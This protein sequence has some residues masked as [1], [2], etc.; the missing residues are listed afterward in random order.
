MAKRTKW[1]TISRTLANGKTIKVRA[2]DT[3]LGR[4][5]ANKA[6]KSLEINSNPDLIKAKAAQ[7]RTTAITNTVNATIPMLANAQNVGEVSKLLLEKYGPQAANL[8]KDQ[9]M[10]IWNAAKRVYSQSGSTSSTQ[11]P[12]AGAESSKPSNGTSKGVYIS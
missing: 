7:R 4:K 11:K 1:V 5:S 12:P 3:V 9:V 10:E 2:K 6:L 8:N